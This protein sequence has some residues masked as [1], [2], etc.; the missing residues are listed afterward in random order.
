VSKLNAL[1]IGYDDS[2]IKSGISALQNGKADKSEITTLADALESKV[3]M[4]AIENIEL[5][6]AAIQT[7]LVKKADNNS[8]ND[9]RKTVE[10][11]VD[12]DLDQT[13]LDKINNSSGSPYDD[14][15]IKDTI[16]TKADSSVVSA[17]ST[18]IDTKADKTLV[19]DLQS[20]LAAKANSTDLA[21]SNNSI[22]VLQGQLADAIARILVLES[23]VS[24]PP[25]KN[26]TSFSGI[27]PID[28]AYGTTFNSLLLP[29]KVT[30]VLNDGSTVDLVATWNKGNYDANT[31]ASY[32]IKANTALLE[33]ISNTNNIEPSIKVTVLPKA[34]ESSYDWQYEFVLSGAGGTSVRLS[35]IPSWNPANK[36]T[37]EDFYGTNYDGTDNTVEIQWIGYVGNRL[38]DPNGVPH[39]TSIEYT[40]G[41][42]KISPDGATDYDNET[43]IVSF[44]G[45]SLGDRIYRIQKV[46][47]V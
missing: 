1:S 34:G 26:I 13:L 4:P 43:E 38:H 15:A 22:A 24:T 8:L 3:G 21:I 33:G 31:A 23:G 39:P 25:L 5:S 42:T 2:E 14:T 20:A 37:L 18:Q 30:A 32:T 47:A 19:S 11:I 16:A 44:A 36:F 12:A 17:L 35:E 27:S 46:S 40:A 41:A 10:K 29:S 28:A 9:Y 7:D 6:I 45:A